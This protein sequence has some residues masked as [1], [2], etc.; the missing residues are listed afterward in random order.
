MISKAGISFFLFDARETAYPTLDSFTPAK[1]IWRV[2]SIRSA[3]E[4]A[5]QA[6]S[7]LHETARILINQVV[8][9]MQKDMSSGS[10][11]MSKAQKKKI[12]DLKK[13]ASRQSKAGEYAAAIA[14]WNAIL[15]LD[16]ANKDAPKA[17]AKIEE[18][19]KKAAEKAK[20]EEMK[21]Q[22][23][24]LAK[25]ADDL[26]KSGD[27]QGAKAKWEEVLAVDEGNKEA[28]KRIEII[29]ETLAAE[30]VAEKDQEVSANLHLA[31]KALG[32]MKYT[33][34]IAAARKVLAAEPGN[35]KAE[36]VIEAAEQKLGE[37]KAAEEEVE[38]APVEPPAEK[39]AEKKVEEK[40][41]EKAEEK[42]APAADPAAGIPCA[43]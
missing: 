39:K 23:D 13:Q 7:T 36:S 6:R 41:E 2:N 27:L 8:D 11:K 38:S 42:E 24:D 19:E 9:R 10:A 14:T 3:K 21:A 28:K 18:A 1:S 15:K 30:S 31:Q 25:E 33:E 4:T 37:A 16:P 40:A 17:I 32:E 22:I 12:R 26:E 29:T 20:A 35:A 5:F 43:Q 34:A